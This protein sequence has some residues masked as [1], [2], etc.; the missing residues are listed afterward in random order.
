[1]MAVTALL[2]PAAVLSQES[3]DTVAERTLDEIVIQAPR[4]IRKPDMDVLYPSESAVGNARNGM[5]LL[6]NLMIPTLTVNDMMGTITASGQPV[7]VRINGREATMEQVRSLLP[8]SIK[9]VEWIDNPG[10]RYNGAAYVLNIIVANPSAGGSLMFSARPALNARFG[11]YS[12]DVKLNMGKSQWSLGSSYKMT[13]D[14][15]GHRDYNE[16]FTYS[17]GH[18]LT[19][20]E[21]PISGAA[22]D[23]KAFAWLTYSHIRP[24]TTVFYVSLQGY[25]N[26]SSREKFQG[27]LQ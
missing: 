26:I 21:E 12:A 8:E 1:M 17:D 16:T 20:I 4:M 15:K 18:S 9:R 25:R 2:L 7:Q 5:Q 23:S 3:A 24:D 14:I 10:L 6:N 11:N 22:D 19:R 13:D 27:I